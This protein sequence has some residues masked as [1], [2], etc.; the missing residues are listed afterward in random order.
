MYP[1]TAVFQLSFLEG[2]YLPS[3]NDEQIENE[4]LFVRR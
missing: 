2:I 1:E 4:D 3:C